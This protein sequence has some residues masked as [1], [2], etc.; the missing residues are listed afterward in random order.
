[1][2]KKKENPKWIYDRKKDNSS[3]YTLGVGGNNFLIC[4]GI[5]PS[6]AEPNKLDNTVKSFERIS[7]RH[8]FDGWLMLNVY[9]QRATNPNDMHEEFD[10]NLHTK[11]LFYIEKHFKNSKT[12]QVLAAW[13]TLIN[14][15]GYLKESLMDIHNLSKKYNCKWYCIGNVSKA[16]HPHH[17]LYLSN[18]ETMKPFDLEKYIKS[19]I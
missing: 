2:N 17:P 1:M 19:I 8:N 14:K 15:R 4:F 18:E 9:P 6:T 16:G 7:K 12:K 13:G 11:N 3:R 5:N 10:K